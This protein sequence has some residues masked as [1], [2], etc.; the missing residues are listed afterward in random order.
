MEV[1]PAI[2]PV[3]RDLGRGDL[4]QPIA[5]HRLELRKR[6]QL[7]GRAVDRVLDVI[8]AVLLLDPA[9]RQFR[10]LG[11]D[12]LGELRA[13]ANREPDQR[14]APRRRRVRF[15]SWRESPAPSD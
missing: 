14:L 4:D 2:C 10:E 1:A 8:A 13:A 7:P 11:E 15:P 5:S 12:S 3:V 9:G 6:G